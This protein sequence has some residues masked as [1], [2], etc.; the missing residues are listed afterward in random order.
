MGLQC[1][2]PSDRSDIRQHMN[3][4]ELNRSSEHMFSNVSVHSA[5]TDWAPTVLVSLQPIKSWRW[6]AWPICSWVDLLQIGSVR[7]SLFHVLWTRFT[8]SYC[9]RPTVVKSFRPR[10]QKKCK[11]AYR[12]GV[13]LSVPLFDICS[14]RFANCGN[15]SRCEVL[16]IHLFYVSWCIKKSWTVL[17]KYIFLSNIISC[18]PIRSSAYDQQAVLQ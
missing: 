7:F 13:C 18:T 10:P 9:V 12:F 14:L 15:S 17:S 1:Y 3:R 2:L 5:W 11:K 8:D 16:P 4:T 6:R